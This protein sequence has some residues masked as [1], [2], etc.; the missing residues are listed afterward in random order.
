MPSSICDA[1]EEAARRI[2]RP[3]RV[4]VVARAAG[5]DEAMGPA[6]AGAHADA[7]GTYGET[8]AVGLDLLKLARKAKP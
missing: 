2:E 7:S 5:A 3:R 8:V 6:D 4:E 1:A